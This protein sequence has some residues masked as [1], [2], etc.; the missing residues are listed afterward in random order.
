MRRNAESTWEKTT[1]GPTT[2]Q[3]PKGAGLGQNTKRMS[4]LSRLSGWRTGPDL[5]VSHMMWST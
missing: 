2:G 5:C 4:P 1:K 3:N